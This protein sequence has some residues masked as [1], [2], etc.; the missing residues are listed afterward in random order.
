MKTDST[1]MQQY[2]FPT[3]FSLT[4]NTV[5]LDETYG[6]PGKHDSLRQILKRSSDM[7]KTSDSQFKT[8]IEIEVPDTSE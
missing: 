2:F 4:S 5:T 1:L 3:K 6:Q 7:Y 8:T